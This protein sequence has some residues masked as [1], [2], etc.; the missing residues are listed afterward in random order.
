MQ[1]KVRVGVIGLGHNGR[2]HAECHRRSQKSDL[3][4]L[5]DRNQ[6]LLYK[7]GEELGVERLYSGD[8]IFDDPEIE[9]ISINTGDSQHREPFLKAVE[10]GKH[11]LVEKPLANSEE[12][13][14]AMVEAAD[15]AKPGLKIQVGY[16]LRFNP[17]FEKIHE[18]ART[19]TLGNV[20]YM[21]A[22]YV[23]NLFYQKQQTDPVTG[24]NWY[25]EN[26]LPMVGGGSHPLDLLRWFKGRQVARVWSCSNHVAFPEMVNDDCMVSLFRFDDGAIAKVAALYGPR[27]EMPPYYNLRL[28]GT[29][30]TVERDQVAV[31]RTNDEAHPPFEPIRA[32]RWRGHPYDPEIEDW[33]DAILEDRPVRTDLRDGA[34]S[35]LATLLAVRSAKEGKEIEVPPLH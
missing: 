19:G 21:E 17:V 18:L 27:R 34:A 4:A 24:E 20:Y 6:D 14:L 13:V 31:A 9:A 3:V 5:S 25:L 33:L 8:D 28:F 23:H 11:V 26:E 16:I 15:R 30:G 22:D 7:T 29:R 2:S 10:A 12:D 1:R 35:T 32:E